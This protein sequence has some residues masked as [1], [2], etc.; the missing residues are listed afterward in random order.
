M[1]KFGRGGFYLRFGLFCLPTVLLLVLNACGL[2]E[3]ERSSGANVSQSQALTLVKS[4]ALLV[5][6]GTPSDVAIRQRLEQLGYQ[7]EEVTGQRSDPAYASGKG[8]VYISESV[9][10]TQ[11]LTKF[12]DVS[13]PVVTSEP[14]VCDDMML[15]GAGWMTDFGES[16][17]QTALLMV[18][19][20]HALNA[21]LS[22]T[23]TITNSPQKYLWGAPNGGCPVRC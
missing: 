17:D 19:S 9:V 7:I 10:S 11:V 15:T 16:V 3:N 18:G 2:G 22:G 4:K 20:P 5:S 12:R 21:G 23:Q 8:L 13:A 6:E 1:V 14:A